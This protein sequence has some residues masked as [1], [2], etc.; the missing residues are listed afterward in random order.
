MNVDAVRLAK[1]M[2]DHL[3]P[4]LVQMEQMLGAA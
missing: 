1:Q 4:Q 2:R 3:Q